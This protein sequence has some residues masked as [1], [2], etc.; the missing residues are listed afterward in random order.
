MTDT[1]KPR[2]ALSV[3]TTITTAR[4][5]ELSAEQIEAILIDWFVRESKFDGAPSDVTIDFDTRHD[6]LRGALIRATSVQRDR[7]S[8]EEQ[9]A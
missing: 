7:V 9:E 8:D 2:V 3:E 5:A 6:Y 4:T 1:S